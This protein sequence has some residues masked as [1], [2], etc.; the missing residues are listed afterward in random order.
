V[1]PWARGYNMALTDPDVALFATTRL[2]QREKSFKWVGPLYRQTWG[3]YA[4]KDSRIII[5]SLDDA[6]QIPRIGTYHEDAKEQFL[7]KKGFV[8]LVSTNKNIS[9]IRHLLQGNIDLW[10]SSDFN[11]PYLAKQAGISPAL[12]RCV[13]AFQKV[14]NYIAFSRQ[15]SD[16]VVEKWQCI[17]DEI[18]R[19]G[20]YERL[21]QKYLHMQTKDLNS[22]GE[23]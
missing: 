14:D 22:E 7:Q 2:P 12:L 5:N 4:K 17:L 16:D 11:M 1:V 18:I 15:T 20:T 9:N 13:Y 6:I 21:N 10:V 23:I 8:N 19:D 3:F